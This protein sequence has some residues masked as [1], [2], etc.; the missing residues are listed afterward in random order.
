MFT[1]A[2]AVGA[3]LARR[4]R[5]SDETAR[6]TAALL[7]TATGRLDLADLLASLSAPPFGW[8]GGA[9]LTPAEQT[10][11][12]ALLE[13]YCAENEVMN[14]GRL[15]PVEKETCLRVQRARIQEQIER[16]ART[17]ARPRR[18]AAAWNDLARL[19]WESGEYE[20]SLASL[21]RALN[22]NAEHPERL[23]SL[24]RALVQLKRD[25]EAGRAFGELLKRWP[26]SARIL[27]EAASL[28]V[29][30]ERYEQAQALLLR[31]LDR[32][33][34]D[35]SA[36]TGLSTVSLAQ[37]RAEAALDYAQRAIAVQ[38]RRPE[39]YRNAALALMRLNRTDDA[40]DWL[41]RGLD[42]NPHH[43]ELRRLADSLK[44]GPRSRRGE[45]AR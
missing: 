31:A 22:E 11:R 2:D 44:A 32:N 29:R 9:S 43:P 42:A 28:E 33:R 3:V 1:E 18:L 8:V 21:R 10:R 36:L 16:L 26:R 35:G 30:R 5:P 37:G 7:S 4:A 6:A 19:Q 12:L 39:P 13:A 34:R 38:P 25:D 14:L 40:R 20:P 24:A 41:A 15:D 45:P 23:L 17:G 27:V